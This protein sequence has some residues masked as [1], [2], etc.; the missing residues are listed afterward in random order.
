MMTGLASS[1]VPIIVKRVELERNDRNNC[2]TTK[3]PV[4][5]ES[6]K[7]SHVVLWQCDAHCNE[8]AAAITTKA[9]GMEDVLPNSSPVTQQS[10][11]RSQ[12][13]G[14]VKAIVPIT[15]RTETSFTAQPRCH[16]GLCAEETIEVEPMVA[17]HIKASLEPQAETSLALGSRE[18]WRPRYGAVTETAAA[19]IR[20]R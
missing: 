4:K 11:V 8:R 15:I 14:P 18:I 1:E 19:S 9:T 17:S 16:L 20:S 2:Q 7:L 12:L 5:D 3:Q 13:D 6:V 10:Q